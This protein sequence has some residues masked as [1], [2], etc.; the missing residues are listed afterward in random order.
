MA[1]RFYIETVKDI[2]N[3]DYLAINVYPILIAEYIEKL[4]SYINDD[5][6][7]YIL[8]NNQK[9]RDRNKYHIT[10]IS[11]AEMSKV[12]TDNITNNSVTDL[13]FMGIGEVKKNDKETY[14]IVV[15]SETLNQIRESLGLEPK[16]FHI[17]IGFNPKDIFGVRKN[18]VTI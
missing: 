2:I 8:T 6:K 9:N 4:K 12:A 5:E 1:Y 13:K 18:E 15:Q 3:N 16:D 17:T 7:F 11:V 10:V 14:F